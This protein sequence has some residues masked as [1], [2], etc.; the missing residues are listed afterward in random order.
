MM[1]LKCVTN[2]L[3]DHGLLVLDLLSQLIISFSGLALL[4]ISTGAVETRARFVKRMDWFKFLL[5]NTREELR[6]TVASIYQN[7]R[8]FRIIHPSSVMLIVY[9]GTFYQKLT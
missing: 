7:K 3:T 5:N 6:E 9:S 4:H 1:K 2:S 8:Y